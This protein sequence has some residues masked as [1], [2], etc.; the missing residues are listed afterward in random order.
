[1][2]VCMPIYRDSY[3]LS[4]YLSS[5]FSRKKMV[6]K[7]LDSEIFMNKNNKCRFSYLY[8]LHND[9]T[10]MKIITI[11]AN[12]KNNSNNIKN[13]DNSIYNGNYNKIK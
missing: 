5:K 11:I 8:L 13:Y 3:H 10:K 9:L 12:N 1:M 7:S 6:N 2:Y 4:I